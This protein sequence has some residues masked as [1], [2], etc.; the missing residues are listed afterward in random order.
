MPTLELRPTVLRPR[1]QMYE[2]TTTNPRRD[3]D[4]DNEIIIHEYGHGVSNRLTGNGNGL[5][6][7]QSGGMG[8][9]WSDWWAMMLTQQ[10]ASETT[11]GRGHGNLRTGPTSD[12]SGNPRLPL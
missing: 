1:M 9:G 4:F 2:W 11:T 8:E 6:A 7:L 3:G 10:S 12:W 5:N